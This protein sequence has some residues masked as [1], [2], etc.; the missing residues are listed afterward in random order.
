MGLISLLQV[1][2]L[3]FAITALALVPRL[4]DATAG[5]VRVQRGGRTSNGTATSSSVSDPCTPN[6]DTS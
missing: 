6:S 4:Y 2:P 1:S 5:A 3:A